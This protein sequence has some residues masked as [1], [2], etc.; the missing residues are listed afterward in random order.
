PRRGRRL[1][2]RA[3]VPE[4]PR[5]AARPPDPRA[6]QVLRDPGPL[7]R[8]RLVG[9]KKNAFT[10]IAV[11]AAAAFGAA[12]GRNAPSATAQEKGGE[13]D[14]TPPQHVTVRYQMGDGG[15]TDVLGV[16]AVTSFAVE[17]LGGD[18][19]FLVCTTQTGRRVYFAY[20]KVVV[21]D[22]MGMHEG[23][24]KAEAPK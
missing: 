13:V 17:S 6:R 2:D 20:E 7:E 18:K 3:R 22:T 23:A 1:R 16:P 8:G 14:K 12:L 19:K 5:E 24:G 15:P 21:V 10:L 9:M 4:R 11:V